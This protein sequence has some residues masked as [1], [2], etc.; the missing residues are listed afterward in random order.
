MISAE[1]ISQLDREAV[2]DLVNGFT[3]ELINDHHLDRQDDEDSSLLKDVN[4]VMNLHQHHLYQNQMMRR[5]RPM[6]QQLN[7]RAAIKN[8]TS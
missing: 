5:S 2:V 8:T 7:T 4:K 1:S 6:S 3:N